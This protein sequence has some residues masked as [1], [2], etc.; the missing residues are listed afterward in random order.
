MERGAGPRPDEW[1][2]EITDAL[3]PPGSGY[4]LMLTPVLPDRVRW[5]PERKAKVRRSN[6]RRRIAK[7]LGPMFAHKVDELMGQEIARRPGYFAGEAYR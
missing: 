7:D 2:K 6:A 1:P 3:P 5:S 4:A